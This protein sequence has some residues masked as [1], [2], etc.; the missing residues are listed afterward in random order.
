MILSTVM[1]R[2]ILKKAK[3]FLAICAN[4]TINFPVIFIPVSSCLRASDILHSN[5]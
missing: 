5:L 1:K 3:N 4:T 2:R